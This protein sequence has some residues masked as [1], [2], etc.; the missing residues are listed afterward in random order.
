MLVLGVGRQNVQ[1]I[2]DDLVNV[3][4]TGTVVSEGYDATM[5]RCYPW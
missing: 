2:Q 4:D 3:V 5:L 1:G